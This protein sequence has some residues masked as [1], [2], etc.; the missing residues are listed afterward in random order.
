MKSIRSVMDNL[1]DEVFLVSPMN[2]DH[3]IKILSKVHQLLSQQSTAAET[4]AALADKFVCNY[5]EE[6]DIVQKNVA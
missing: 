1:L 3:L 6:W 5:R 4:I 2:A